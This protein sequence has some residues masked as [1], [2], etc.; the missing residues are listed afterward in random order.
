MLHA[1]KLLINYCC[2]GE[3]ARLASLAAVQQHLA[4]V[5]RLLEDTSAL[6]RCAA[7]LLPAGEHL[8]EEEQLLHAGSEA[9]D[10]EA[11]AEGEAVEVVNEDGSVDHMEAEGGGEGTAA[12]GAAREDTDF[13]DAFEDLTASG[14]VPAHT[15]GGLAA[16]STS[17]LR[18]GCRR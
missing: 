7:Q 14:E 9:G 15:L 4:A 13:E 5:G 16:A 18:N 1:V 3:A 11:H 17:K 6:Q 12:G 10:H 2:A 8:P